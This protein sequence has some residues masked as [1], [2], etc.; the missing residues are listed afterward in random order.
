MRVADLLTEHSLQ[1]RLETPSGPK[2]LGQEIARCA[3]TE[4]LDPTPFLDANVLLLTSGIGM[5]FTEQSIWDGY[6]ERLTRVPV[7]ALAFAVGTAHTTLPKGLVTACTSHDLP[8]LEVPTT[9]PLLKIDQHVENM[10]QAEHIARLDLGWSLADECAR[11]ASQGAEV[12]TLLAA[13]YAALKS[14]IAVYD[15]FGSLIAQYPEA[16]TWR[17]GANYAEQLDVLTVPLPMGLSNP[18]QLA[19]RLYGLSSEYEAL[20]APVTSILALQL[21]RSVAVDASSHQD[22][23]RFVNRC[24][25]WSESTRSDVA[26]A[27]HELGLSRRAET[28]LLVADI[29]G[30]HAA[31]AWKLRVALHDRFHDVRIAELDNQLIALVQF[32]REAFAEAMDGLLAVHPEL[33]LVLRG[34]T[35]TIDEL[36]IALVHALDLVHHVKRPVLAPVLGLSA[37]VA[38][39]AGRGA[40]ES[41][42][43]F[44]APSSSTTSSAPPSCSPRC[45]RGCATTPSPRAPARN[46]SSTATR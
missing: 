19:V 5:N 34:P 9:V 7:A 16:V 25:G 20:L 29:S 22:M 18:C 10:L 13:I 26:N 11:L 37:V 12:S 32:P 46:S 17:T 2:R 1:L 36:R 28:T 23:L 42:E 24:V 39:A 14:P 38:A 4:H 31:A 45:A 44:L 41:A 3:P 27:F 6:V 15:A 35:H 30:D 8:L 21:N 43:R 40:R 33:P